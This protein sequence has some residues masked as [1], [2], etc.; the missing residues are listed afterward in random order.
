MTQAQHSAAVT[1]IVECLMAA[2]LAATLAADNE[3]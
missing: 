1:G 2:M 3:F